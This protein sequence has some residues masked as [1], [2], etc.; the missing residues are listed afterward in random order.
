MESGAIPDESIKNSSAWNSNEDAK[1]SR[2]NTKAT[3]HTAGSWVSLKNEIGEWLEI[4]LENLP[5]IITMIATQGRHGPYV[6]WVKRYKLQYVDDFY[7]LV[8]YTEEGKN[9]AKVTTLNFLCGCMTG[10]YR[11]V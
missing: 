1:F 9:K 6:Q 10:N 4:N 7:R 3:H 5:A 8:Y 2:I 11:V